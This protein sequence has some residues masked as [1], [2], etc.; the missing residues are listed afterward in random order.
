MLTIKAE[1]YNEDTE[2][3]YFSVY[4]GKQLIETFESEAEAEEYIASGAALTDYIDYKER[5][6]TPRL[7]GDPRP[8]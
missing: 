2:E 3:P 4:M 5:G 8:H 6:S 7:G 1:G